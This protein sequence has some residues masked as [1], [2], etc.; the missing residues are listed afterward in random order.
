MSTSRKA[1]GRRPALAWLLAAVIIGFSAT[2]SAQEGIPPGAQGPPIPPKGYLVEEIDSGL[3]WATEGTYQVMFLVGRN[4]VILVDAPPSIG[5]NLL[6]AVAETTDNP[7]THLVLSHSH[8]DHI[9]AANLIQ[10]AYPQ[11]E[12]IAHRETRRQIAEARRDNPQDPR[13]LPTRIFDNRKFV[14][15][16]SQVLMLDYRG[17][18]HEPGNIFIFAPRQCVLMVVDV[19]FPGW[20]P[21]SSLALAEEVRSFIRAHDEILTFDFDVFIGGH[22]TRLGSRQDVE[23]AKAYVLDVQAKAGMA[24]GMVDFFEVFQRSGPDIFN[25]FSIFLDEVS[26]LCEAMVIPQWTHLGGVVGFTKS[27]CFAMQNFLR[28]D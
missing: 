22:L 26:S 5:E 25:V 9:G 12:I 4:G 23:E 24:L 2:I 6:A 14:R 10:E 21:F 20:V 8:R 11:V 13:P 28:L 3:Y 17:P 16:G 15:S 27:H 1:T 7:I 19:V 18:V